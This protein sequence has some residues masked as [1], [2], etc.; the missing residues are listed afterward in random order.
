MY[1]GRGWWPVHFIHN[2]VII[3]YEDDRGSLWVFLVQ[4]ELCIFT[5]ECVVHNGA[6]MLSFLVHPQFF[7]AA[8]ILFSL[9]AMFSRKCCPDNFTM[10]SVWGLSLHQNK[11]P[12][13]L[14]KLDIFNAWKTLGSQKLKQRST[15]KAHKAWLLESDAATATNTVRYFHQ[16]MFKF[17]CTCQSLHFD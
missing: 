16:R 17:N 5:S 10:D 12:I 9:Y 11:C 7:L 4:H 8:L 6:A 2:C 3:Y 1:R 14:A 15:L 13:S